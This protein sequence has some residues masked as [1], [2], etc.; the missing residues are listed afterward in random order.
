MYRF[1][2]AI[3][4][5]AASA[6]ASASQRGK[7]SAKPWRSRAIQYATAQIE[8]QT[9]VTECWMPRLRGA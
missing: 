9:D 8:K 3:A 2:P 4:L 1:T 7:A 5:L 6:K